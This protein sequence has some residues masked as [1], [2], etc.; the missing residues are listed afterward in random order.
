MRNL[1][2]ERGKNMK[3][4]CPVAMAM[5]VALDTRLSASARLL[6]QSIL[7]K[8][9][10]VGYCTNTNAELAEES[11]LS[12]RHISRLI[13]E[14]VKFGYIR[15]RL[16]YYRKKPGEITERRLYPRSADVAGASKALTEWRQ[17]YG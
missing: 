12:C 5:E 6:Y 1:K 16:I 3:K 10:A 4:D 2:S 9:A 17:E 13:S 7:T 11:N 15:R 14:L 8:A